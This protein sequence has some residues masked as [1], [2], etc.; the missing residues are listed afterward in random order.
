MP[1]KQRSRHLSASLRGQEGT[2]SGD[3][4]RCVKSALKAQG[5]GR[6]TELEPEA[7]ESVR[8]REWDGRQV[9]GGVNVEELRSRMKGGDR[10]EERGQTRP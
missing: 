3:F 2:A 8:E 10:E 5:R 1:L 4:G 7:L 6:S 9:S